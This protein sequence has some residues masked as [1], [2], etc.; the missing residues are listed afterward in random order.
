MV[1]ALEIA[2]HCSQEGA[3]TLRLRIEK[4][5]AKRGVV[6]ETTIVRSGH[7]RGSGKAGKRGLIFG[8]RSSLL[9]GR[10][11]QSAVFLRPDEKER[12]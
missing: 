6:I 10:P 4:H 7:D 3:E 12:V 1:E 9:D 8:V 11:S 5:W 2:D